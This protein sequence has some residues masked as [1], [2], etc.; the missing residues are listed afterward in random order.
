[1][2]ITLHLGKATYSVQMYLQVFYRLA[3]HA[4]VN[5]LATKLHFCVSMGHTPFY[6]TQNLYIVYKA[7]SA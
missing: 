2:Y 1:M 4:F 3:Y 6:V 5:S 7:Y